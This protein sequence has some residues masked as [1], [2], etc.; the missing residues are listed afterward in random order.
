MQIIADSFLLAE[1]WSTRRERS[2]IGISK[3]HAADRLSHS[4]VQMSQHLDEKVQLPLDAKERVFMK[5]FMGTMKLAYGLGV[6][7]L[8]TM[9]AQAAMADTTYTYTGNDFT[10]AEGPFSTSDFVSGSFTVAA[11]LPDDLPYTN[12]TSDLIGFSFSD[13]PGN[14][15][16]AFPGTAFLNS[17]FS[18]STDSA[19]HIAQWDIS[20]Q[21]FSYPYAADLISTANSPTEVEDFGG[22]V[23]IGHAD[24][25]DD[26]G[27]WSNATPPTPTPEPESLFLFGTGALWIVGLIRRK[28]AG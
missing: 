14:F 26:P 13:V 10:Y 22:A 3:I 12:I 1:Q 2:E 18:V 20:I 27:T 9:G 8:A 5:L 21:Q 28:I 7:L 23:E 24:V 16:F 4:S 15:P 25:V 17:T 19:G 11:P 6:L